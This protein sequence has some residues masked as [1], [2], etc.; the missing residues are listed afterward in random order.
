MTVKVGAVGYPGQLRRTG[1]AAAGAEQDP[2]HPTRCPA[3][4]G[5]QEHQLR[6]AR[7]VD[8]EVQDPGLGKPGANV[9]RD[10]QQCR[11]GHIRCGSSRRSK[12]APM[13]WSTCPGD[14]ARLGQ[15]WPGFSDFMIYILYSSIFKEIQLQIFIYKFRTS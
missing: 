7:P 3:P 5:H 4:G 8:A 9:G 10:L 6:L 13:W 1:C 11:P 15:Y 2:V 12:V 14:N